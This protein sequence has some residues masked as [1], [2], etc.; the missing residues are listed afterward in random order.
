MKKVEKLIK[1]TSYDKVLH[2]D[3][4][5]LRKNGVPRCKW[6]NEEKEL[7]KVGDSFPKQ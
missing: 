6:S 5:K 3:S 4:D 1:C 7:Y 2:S